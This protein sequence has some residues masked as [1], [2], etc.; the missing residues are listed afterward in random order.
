MSRQ[1]SNTE[2]LFAGCNVRVGN[3]LGEVHSVD[4]LPAVPCGIVAVH[5]IKFTHRR[6]RNFGQT[7]SVVEIKPKTERVNYSFI[8]VL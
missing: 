5:T 8:H 4:L 7:F 3:L 6:C 1:I 2:Q